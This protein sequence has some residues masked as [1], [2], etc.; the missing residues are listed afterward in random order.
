MNRWV[1]VGIIEQTARQKTMGTRVS[2]REQGEKEW[3]RRGQVV[4]L[5]PMAYAE[6]LPNACGRW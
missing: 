5:R 4:N 6:A 2:E 1:R 3:G